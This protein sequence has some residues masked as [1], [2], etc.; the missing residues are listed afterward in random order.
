MESKKLLVI[1]DTHGSV[2]VLRT[3]LKWAKDRLPPNDTICCAAFCGDGISDLQQAA[4]AIGFYSDWKYVKGNNDYDAHSVVDSTVFNFADH[5][6][7]LCHGHRH[8]LYSGYFSLVNAAQSNDADIV[9]FG[10]THIPLCK[11]EN[12][13]LLVNP[14]SAGSP[15]SKTGSTFAVIEF[16]SG[17]MPEVKFWGINSGADI[18]EVRLPNNLKY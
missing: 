11:R 12:N 2:L 3:V 9:L 16:M 5:R 18:R 14:G 15:R 6:F 17:E 4:A 13:I 8:N 10:H 1:S 7:Y